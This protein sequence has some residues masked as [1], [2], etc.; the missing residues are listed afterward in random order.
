PF[1][2]V[3]EQILVDRIKAF[4]PGFV[5]GTTTS[6]K[7]TTPTT[8][9]S[10]NYQAIITESSKNLCLDI[11]GEQ[12]RVG[13]FAIVQ[14]CQSKNSQAWAVFND[15]TIRPK[16]SSSLCLDAN[17]QQLAQL[18]QCNNSVSQRWQVS[19]K[20][21][22]NM[23]ANDAVLDVFYSHSY[24][25]G[26]YVGIWPKHGYSNQQWS[27]GKQG[28]TTINKKQCS[29]QYNKITQNRDELQ[30]CTPM[31][32]L[33]STWSNWYWIRIPN[34]A[35]ITQLEITVQG[36]SGDANLFVNHSSKGWPNGYNSDF[37]SVNKGNSERVVITNPQKGSDY[38]IQ[39]QAETPYKGLTLEVTM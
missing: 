13:A 14:T 30:A 7:P 6:T 31:T 29:G 20:F 22:Q 16:Q 1:Y 4:A 11:R 32:G 9:T 10:S 3:N 25:N 36:G 17:P 26:A 37:R 24:G 28:S 35:S 12:A 39:I 27:M 18:N 5:P 19:G 23:G 15:G 21:I 38:F 8:T 2:K 33:A 34:N